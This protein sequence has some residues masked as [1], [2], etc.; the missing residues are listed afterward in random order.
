MNNNRANSIV[1]HGSK[2]SA[3][4]TTF[5]FL[6]IYV[7]YFALYMPDKIAHIQQGIVYKFSINQNF[8]SL[9]LAL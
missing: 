2:I 3:L 4:W 9:H 6:Y 7:D 8:Y 5:M 1:D